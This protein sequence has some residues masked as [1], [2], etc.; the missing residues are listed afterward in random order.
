MLNKILSMIGLPLGILV[1]LKYFGIYDVSSRILF[2]ITMIGALFLI[3]IQLL[4]YIS[5]SR[6]NE[7]TSLMGKAIKTILAVPGILYVIDHFYPI[8]LPINLEIFIAI[9]LFT[10]GLYGLH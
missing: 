1:I 2:N 3:V 6:Y 4:S 8:V 7:G 9:F 10:E 5:V